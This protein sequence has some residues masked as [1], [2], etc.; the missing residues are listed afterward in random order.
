MSEQHSPDPVNR[1]ARHL[2]TRRGQNG[3]RPVSESAWRCEDLW[4]PDEQ[5]DIWQCIDQV[6]LDAMRERGELDEEE[7]TEDGHD[8]A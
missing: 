8:Q 4:Q 6:E 1:A 5:M 7:G 2:R 3:S